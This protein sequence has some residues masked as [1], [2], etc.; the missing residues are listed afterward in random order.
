MP[1]HLFNKDKKILKILNFFKITI[2]IVLIWN[3][4]GKPFAY[5]TLIYVFVF[6]CKKKVIQ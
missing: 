2:A 1:L 4:L 3:F 5:K 6:Y